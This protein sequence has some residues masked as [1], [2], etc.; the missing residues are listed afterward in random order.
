MPRR[1]DPDGLA[2]RG[3]EHSYAEDGAL[4]YEAIFREAFASA[5]SDTFA[6]LLVRVKDAST[7]ADR[8]LVVNGPASIRAWQARP[9]WRPCRLH[10]A[11]RRC[12]PKTY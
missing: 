12:G 8:L 4:R 9:A 5:R 6:V 11:P 3:L 1:P 2:Q 7:G 10:Q